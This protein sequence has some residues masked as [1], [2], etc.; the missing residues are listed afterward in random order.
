M[1]IFFQTRKTEINNHDQ[2]Y[3]ARRIEGLEKFFSPHAHA[4]IDLERT[5]NS[6][7]GQDIYYA[8]IRI[9]DGHY[10]YFAEEYQS[11]TRKSFDHAYGDIYRII[12]KD[13]SK[14]KVIMRSA[15]RAFKKIFRRKAR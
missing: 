2:D 3:I 5:R 15:G 12:R 11:D 14:S 6:H 10:K 4:Y 9:K 13:R 8:A 7:N 1:Q